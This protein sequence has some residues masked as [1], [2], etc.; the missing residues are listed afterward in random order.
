MLT[1]RFAVIATLVVSTSG[2]PAAAQY[3]VEP[4]TAVE[5]VLA[6]WNEGDAV[7]AGQMASAY[8]EHAIRQNGHLPSNGAGLAFIAAVGEAMNDWQNEGPTYW[9]W[10]AQLHENACGPMPEPFHAIIRQNA[11]R[12][13]SSP[14]IDRH[15]RASPFRTAA[16]GP[17]APDN[18][19]PLVPSAPRDVSSERALAIFADRSYTEPLG[20]GSGSRIPPY[21]RVELLYE[22]PA[23]ALSPVLSGNRWLSMR[24]DRAF[25]IPA[26]MTVLSPCAPL[27]YL[28]GRREI[29]LCRVDVP[30]ASP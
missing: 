24:T 29:E 17:C 5:D 12:P 22:Y 3:P 20:G 10:V 6:A 15:L 11:Y 14:S 27:T 13:G 23:G 16:G 26:A 7:R 1:S 8:L 18:A 19:V 30:P 21:A 2:S 9:L 4:A 25:S 28:S